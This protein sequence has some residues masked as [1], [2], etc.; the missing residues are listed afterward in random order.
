M[1]GVEVFLISADLIW[2]GKCTGSDW[3]ESGDAIALPI[4]A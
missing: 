2:G 3:V 1:D 4:S